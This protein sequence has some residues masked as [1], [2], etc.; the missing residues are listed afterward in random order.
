MRKFDNAKEALVYLKNE[1][2]EGETIILDER[3]NELRPRRVQRFTKS[4]K[5]EQA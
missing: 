2:K 1:A 5:E 3:A 4:K